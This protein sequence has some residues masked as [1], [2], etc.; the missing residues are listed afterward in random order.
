LS[1]SFWLLWVWRWL[2]CV[3]SFLQGWSLP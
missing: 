3:C 1:D 2:R